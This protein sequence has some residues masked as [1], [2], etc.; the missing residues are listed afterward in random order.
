MTADEKKWQAES[1]ARTLMEAIDIQN[2]T[3][4]YNAA[5]REIKS[6]QKQAEQTA[7][8]ANKLVKSK[9]TKKKSTKKKR[10]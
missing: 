4:R 9:T 6:I 5:L 2:K 1:D 3:T 10:K 8:K 7:K